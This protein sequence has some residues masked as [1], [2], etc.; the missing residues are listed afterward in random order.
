MDPITQQTALASAGAG[1]GAVSID[2]LFSTTTYPGT[3]SAQSINNTIDLA[4]EGGMVW[5]KRRDGSQEHILGDTERTNFKVLRSDDSAAQFGGTNYISQ[6]NNNGFNLGTD[7]GVNAN[8]QT[9]VSWSF[10]KAPG[11]F[12]VVTYT[13]NGVAGREIAHNLGSVPGMVIVKRT[14]ASEDWT[15]YHRS[16][17]PNKIIDLNSTN[18][19]NNSGDIFDT[20]APTS[21]VFTVGSSARVNSN[22]STYVAYIFGHDDLIQCGNYT[23]TGSSNNVNVG[24]EPQFVMIKRA[25]GTGNWVMLDSERDPNRLYANGTAGEASDAPSWG[26]FTSTGFNVSGSTNDYNNGGHDYIYIAIK[27]PDPYD[28]NVG[29]YYPMFAV[30]ALDSKDDAI[31]STTSETPMRRALSFDTAHTTRLFGDET[32]SDIISILDSSYYTCNPDFGSGGNNISGIM[33]RHYK[34]DG[35]LY[36]GG[37]GSFEFNNISDFNIY[38]DACNQSPLA[39]Q[40]PDGTGSMNNVTRACGAISNVALSDLPSGFNGTLYAYLNQSSQ[41]S[42]EAQAATDGWASDLGDY[43][44]IGITT[45]EHMT[46]TDALDREFSFTGVDKKSGLAFGISDSEGRGS[47]A[48]TT[49]PR[50]GISRRHE[51]YHSLL[52]NTLKP[53]SGSEGNHGGQTD[54]GYFV[55]YGKY[56]S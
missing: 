28:Y 37:Q 8:T 31:P 9:Y 45:K 38:D 44:F 52:T 10:R 40:A 43:V 51:Q 22:G 39:S 26:G 2:D 21:S 42:G 30:K 36:T 20:T 29:S 7:A 35:T 24:F 41:K 27:A 56:L 15:C 50:Q 12:D 4:N 6:Y 1:G 55:V 3:G 17:W 19:E 34:S 32:V 49:T 25:S 47:N 16:L 23:G 5:I 54:E 33:I 13:G 14:N 11:F 48:G 53:K 18:A 46:D